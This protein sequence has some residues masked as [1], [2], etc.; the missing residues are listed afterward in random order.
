M[1]DLSLFH[2]T[3]IKTRP[4][5]H[6]SLHCKTISFKIIDT[7]MLNKILVILHQKKKAKISQPMKM[8]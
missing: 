1:E 5:H 4:T 6:N 2:N 3:G 8:V 7:K